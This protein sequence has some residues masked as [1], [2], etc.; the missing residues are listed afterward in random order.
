MPTTRWGLPRSRL[1]RSAAS[2]G[3]A[4]QDEEQRAQSVLSLKESVDVL[5][6]RKD[7][8]QSVLR[9]PMRMLTAA[10]VTEMENA[11]NAKG[12]QRTIAKEAQLLLRAIPSKAWFDALEPSLA[13]RAGKACIGIATIA[14]ETDMALSLV[15]DAVART[16]DQA[17]PIADGFLK[18]WEMRLSP[19]SDIDED[20]MM[21]YF[22][23]DEIA[24]APLTR[25]RQRRNLAASAASS[26]HSAP[27]VST[28]ARSPPSRPSS[29][30]A[31]ASPRFMT[32]QTSSASSV[33][34]PKSPPAQAPP[35]PPRWPRA[36]TAIGATAPRRRSRASSAPIPKSPNS[37]T[38]GTAS[39][40]NSSIAPW[41]ASR[42]RGASPSSRRASPTT[43]CS[44]GSRRKGRRLR[45]TGRVQ[46]QAFA[47]FES[48]ADRYAA[49]VAAGNEREDIGVYER[50]FGAAMGTSQ[51][52]FITADDLPTEGGEAPKDDQVEKVKKAI[53]S[54]PPDSAFRHISDFARVMGAAVSRADP[55]V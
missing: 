43:A 34:S 18:T 50:W 29:R 23:R 21:Y 39:P 10:L 52:N 24:Q 5:L 40:S 17:I 37:L 48:A 28:P 12:R 15:A 4:K 3:D 25:G 19:K 33:P 14:D 26:T 42:A 13:V 45:Q 6:E 41:P 11:I 31:T 46:A 30:P 47:A 51:L 49:A 2:I 27:P 38:R 32:L 36:L 55:E 44:S 16:P 20:A 1:S 7:L 22:W 53:A 9:V 54:L 35:S 8:D